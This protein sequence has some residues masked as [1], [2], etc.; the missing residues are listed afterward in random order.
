MLQAATIA[1]ALSGKIQRGDAWAATVQKLEQAA[2]GKLSSAA[3]KKIAGDFESMFISQMVEQMFTGDS[4]GGDAFGS[5]ESDE[6]YKSMMVDE[7]A[8]AIVKSGG[9]G[10]ADYVK[11]ELLK[12]QEM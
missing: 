6:I 3:V 2:D 5:P 8:K 12:Q 10:I 4:L 11:R 9:I 1:N 7:Y